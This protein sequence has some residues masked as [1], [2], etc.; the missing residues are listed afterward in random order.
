MPAA[1]DWTTQ[2]AVTPVKN[3]GSCGSC[4]AFATTGAIEGIVAIRNRTLLSLSEQQLV[5]CDKTSSGCEGGWP[6]RAFAYVNTNNGLCT[7]AAYPYTAQDGACR[8]NSCVESPLTSITGYYDVPARNDDDALMRAVAQQPVSVAVNANAAF[9]YYA[10]GVF[11]A[12]CS[13]SINHAV[14]IVGYGI[15]QTQVP[16][17]KIKNSWGTA[18]GEAGYI[19]LLRNDSINGGAGLCGVNL[20]P[21]YPTL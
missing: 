4:W 5:D 9:Q 17:W 10:S 15:T 8:S 14:L 3:Q 18:W 16:Y 2:N 11:T 7:E 6:D 13:G 20:Y 19:R 12:P 21:S 1:V